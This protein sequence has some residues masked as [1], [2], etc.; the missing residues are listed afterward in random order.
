[1]NIKTT[2][3]IQDWVEYIERVGEQLGG[4][5]EDYEIVAIQVLDSEFDNYPDTQLEDAFRTFLANKEKE[6]AKNG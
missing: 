6:L 1:M 4:K 3:T 5:Y 2:K